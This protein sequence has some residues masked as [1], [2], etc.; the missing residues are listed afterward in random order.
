MRF[1]ELTANFISRSVGEYRNFQFIAATSPLAGLITA[2]QL[3]GK[4][5]L[6][7]TVPEVS[8]SGGQRRILAAL[9]GHLDRDHR[10]RLFHSLAN[11]KDYKSRRIVIRVRISLDE[12]QA[13]SEL[14]LLGY[15]Q[16]I[17]IHF[18]IIR[19]FIQNSP[20]DIDCCRTNA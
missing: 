2:R 5:F 4:Y 10:H 3:Q 17:W 1:C 18:Q 7:S 6:L 14:I 16:N 15:F 12:H 13:V 11:P 8:R 20:R 9:C 19:I